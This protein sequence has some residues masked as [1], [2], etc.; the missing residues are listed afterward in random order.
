[1]KKIA[2]ALILILIIALPASANPY[3]LYGRGNCTYFAYE[4][5]EEFWGMTPADSE[6]MERLG[7]GTVDWVRAGRI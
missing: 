2:L 7:M 4:C 5:V 3:A 1:M 6:V